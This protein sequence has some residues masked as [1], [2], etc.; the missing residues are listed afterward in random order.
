M[1]VLY[2]ENYTKNKLTYNVS[3]LVVSCGLFNTDHTKIN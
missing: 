3:H 2:V 1:N